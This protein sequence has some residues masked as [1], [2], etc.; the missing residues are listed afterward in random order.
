MTLS[1]FLAV[2]L[3]AEFQLIMLL[4]ALYFVVLGFVATNA[5]TKH[6]LN[7]TALT[8]VIIAAI[9]WLAGRWPDG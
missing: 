9:C 1:R 8:L 5:E 6:T 7:G 4:L 3:S 2:L